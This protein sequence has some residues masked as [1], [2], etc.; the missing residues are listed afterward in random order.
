MSTSGNLKKDILEPRDLVFS[1]QYESR[2][3]GRVF[4][5]KGASLRTETY[6]GG[7]IFCDAASGFISLHN[8]TTF[9]SEET[10][11]SKLKFE[12]ED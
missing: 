3:D 6:K 7:T 4:T 2:L 9:T 10:I 1:D 12:R 8:Q 11:L 5:Y